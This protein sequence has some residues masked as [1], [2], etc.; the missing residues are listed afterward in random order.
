MANRYLSGN[1][2][3]VT[4]ERTEFDLPVSGTIPDFL[5]GRYLRNG[6]NP[7]TPPDP[8]TYHWFTGEGMVHGIRIRDG[9]AEWYRNRWVRA[10][11]VPAALG[12]D[13]P[14]GP[15]TPGADFADNTNVIGLGGRTFALVEAGAKPVEMNDELATVGRWDFGGGLRFGYTAHPKVDPLTGH[16]HAA[17]YFWANPGAIEYVVVSADGAVLHVE[18]VAVPGSPMVHD[19]SITENHV[20]LYDMC[21][22]FDQQSA[23]AGSSFP[24]S[25]NPDYGCRL[26]VITKDRSRRSAPLWFEVDPCYVFHAM[27]SFERIDERGHTVI[28][29]D[30][31]RHDRVFDRNPL[32]PDE[33]VPTLWRWELNLSTGTVR[34]DQ[35]DDTPAEFPRIDERRVGLRYRY[36]FSVGMGIKGDS[37]AISFDGA[38]LNRHDMVTGQVESH[39]AGTH[40]AV[41]EAVFI[42]SSENAAEL[43][44]YL[45][46]IAYDMDTDRSELRIISAEDISGDPVARIHLPVRVPF[47]FHGNWVP[48]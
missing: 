27:N 28:V 44:G 10:G 38:R 3:P 25:W 1:F 47:G 48:S 15:G 17:N 33:S 29:V 6:P 20:V 41:G 34:G 13:D 19:V 36:G 30:A 16:L 8:S 35:I 37:G 23:F 31:V 11:A 18:D 45:M 12:E 2:A 5:D 39:V 26:G 14:G 42:P 22:T 40:K 32:A 46:S 21:V 24:Y 4:E 43:Q 7:V 9:R